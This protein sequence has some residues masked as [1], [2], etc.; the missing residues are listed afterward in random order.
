MSNKHTTGPW[1]TDR[2]N[3]HSGQI[4]TIHGCIGNG[5]I[6]VWSPEACFASEEEQEANARLIAAAPE[7]LAEIEREYTELSDIGNDWQGRHTIAGQQK[8]CRL[9]DLICKAIGSD[10]EDVQDDYGTRIANATGA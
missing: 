1:E 3:V 8:L 7:L 9:R 10:A 2:N 4:A 5:W 6:E